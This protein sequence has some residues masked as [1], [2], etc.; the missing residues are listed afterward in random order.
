[1]G[2]R[3]ENKITV[4]VRIGN[5][6]S[7]KTRAPCLVSLPDRILNTENGRMSALYSSSAFR[8]AQPMGCAQSVFEIS[9]HRAEGKSR[10]ENGRDGDAGVSKTTLEL[11]RSY[12]VATRAC[13]REH[14]YHGTP[15]RRRGRVAVSRSRARSFPSATPRGPASA[16]TERRSTQSALA[17]RC[18]RV[19]RKRGAI[20]RFRPAA[21]RRPN[22]V[23]VHRGREFGSLS[24]AATLKYIYITF[25]TIVNCG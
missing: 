15:Q 8:Q 24:P 17:V 9:N 3:I 6:Y 12:G 16:R 18:R 11:S 10:E 1:M 25:V 5:A 4:C 19:I 13:P 21:A 7:S 14:G 22:I 2:E 20:A 23:R